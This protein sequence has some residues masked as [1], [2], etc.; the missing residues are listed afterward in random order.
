MNYSTVI[1]VFLGTVLATACTDSP[2]AGVICD[3]MLFATGMNGDED[4]GEDITMKGNKFHFNQQLAQAKFATGMNGDEDL[5]EDITMKGNKFHF[6]QAPESHALF[7]TGMN[8]DEDLGEDITMKGNKFH[9]I[10]QQKL[11]QF[12]TGMNGDEDLGEDITMKGNKF[13]FSQALAEVQGEG[14]ATIPKADWTGYEFP[15]KVHTL[16]PKAAKRNT[17]FYAQV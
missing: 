10:Q 5:G 3:H 9:F 6:N 15:D 12:A 7:A 14:D 16:D 8:G 2:V 11:A 13:H 17:G 1:A 4:L